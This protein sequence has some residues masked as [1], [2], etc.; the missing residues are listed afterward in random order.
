MEKRE[1]LKIQLLRITTSS[2]I[3]ALIWLSPFRAAAQHFQAG[4]LYGSR[5]VA[6]DDIKRVYGQGSVYFPF[7][8]VVWKGIIFGGGYEG[9]Y[10]RQGRIGLFNELATLKIDGWELF[11]GYQLKLKS[12]IAP[13]FKLGL[14]SCAYKQTIENPSLEAFWKEFRVDHKKTTLTGAIGLRLFPLKIIFLTGEVKYIPMKVKPYSEEVDLSG[15]RFLGGLG[16]S[17]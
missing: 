12:V 1:L 2:F 13:F 11:L 10:N 14:A 3:L 7:I 5:Q 6:D 17:F 9:G 8:E 4:F 16:L 15:L